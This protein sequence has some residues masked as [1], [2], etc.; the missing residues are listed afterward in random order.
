[1]V[2]PSVCPP[3]ARRRI[4]GRRPPVRPPVHFPVRPPD[5][6]LAEE[7][8]FGHRRLLHWK[9]WGDGST[10]V[11]IATTRSGVT[12]AAEIGRAPNAM[13]ARPGSGSKSV[14]PSSCP[15]TIFTPSR[16]CPRSCARRSVATRSC[17]TVC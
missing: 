1:M 9:S 7:G 8:T 12:T 5:D 4:G 6:A 17:C 13:G 10:A 2:D 11:T 16:P 3:K 14:K 15:A